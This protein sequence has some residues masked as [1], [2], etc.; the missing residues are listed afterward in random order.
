MPLGK[1]SDCG[2]A[3]FAGL[4]VEQCADLNS[5][6]DVRPHQWLLRLHTARSPQCATSCGFDFVVSPLV[7]CDRNTAEILAA[8]PSAPGL[9]KAPFPLDDVVVAH[10]NW[11]SQVR[12]DHNHAP[13][14]LHHAQVV[15]RASSWIAAD[16]PDAQLA[17]VSVSQ[18]NRELQWAM[19]LGLQAVLLPR[20]SPGNTARYAHVLHQVG[21]WRSKPPSGCWQRAPHYAQALNSLGNMAMWHP[22]TLT[23]EE[24]QAADAWMQWHSIRSLCEHH[25]LLGAALEIGPD[26]PPQH[27]V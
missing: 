14:S 6:V 18:L 4:E 15:G 19:H 25:P 24:A 7:N 11:S 9:V 23:G 12:M 17:T 27:M 26:L 10:L 3:R 2:C 13:A 20:Q 8:P 1:R 22:I 21:Q 16:A 5:V